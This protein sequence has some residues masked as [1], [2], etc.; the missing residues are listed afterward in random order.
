MVNPSS[1]RHKGFVIANVSER[2]VVLV[3]YMGVGST[4]GEPYGK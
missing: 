3:V 2:V 1:E 4:M